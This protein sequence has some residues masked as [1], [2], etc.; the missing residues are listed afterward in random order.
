MRDFGFPYDTMPSQSKLSSSA[1]IDG[2]VLHLPIESKYALR[3]KIAD[4]EDK[5]TN[6]FFDK[7]PVR[8]YFD[9]NVRVKYKQPHFDTIDLA[10]SDFLLDETSDPW[11][12]ALFEAPHA[13][14]F[15]I[16]E[17]RTI[18]VFE[19][20]ALTI[21]AEIIQSDED[22]KQEFLN[23]PRFRDV[24]DEIQR[25]KTKVERRLQE[26]EEQKQKD[27]RESF[28]HQWKWLEKKREAGEFDEFINQ[29]QHEGD[30]KKD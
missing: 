7:F 9:T 21:S 22:L 1:I 11:I 12:V 29:M 30:G 4:K 24:Y 6:F 23:D 3:T 8:K 14:E 25:E 15:S 2:D 18:E 13:V 28:F 26:E 19:G 16:Q 20:N 17:M 27:K 5:K 10:I